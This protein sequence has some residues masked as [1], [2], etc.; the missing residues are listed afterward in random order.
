MFP[1]PIKLNI[2]PS[3]PSLIQV[4]RAN[5]DLGIGQRYVLRSYRRIYSQEI[6][7]RRMVGHC[8]PHV[9]YLAVSPHPPPFQ[10]MS[11][12]AEITEVGVEG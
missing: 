10:I 3:S 9:R 6:P 12:R 7:R 4:H 1:N 8:S 5:D 2:A 11:V